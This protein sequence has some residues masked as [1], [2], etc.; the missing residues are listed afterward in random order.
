MPAQP[1]LY[2]CFRLCAPYTTITPPQFET[3]VSAYASI[4]CSLQYGLERA[5]YELM[6][7]KTAGMDW[8]DFR[9]YLAASL[10]ELHSVECRTYFREYRL[11]HQ[12]EASPHKARYA[13]EDYREVKLSCFRKLKTMQMH[14]AQLPLT[15]G[16]WVA[17]HG[18][19]AEKC[20]CWL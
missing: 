6:P 19:Q 18:A 16:C 14:K 2:A 5:C 20:T 8:S 7:H 12:Y 3:M 4:T 1:S 9:G 17:P 13:Y 11:Q 10:S 15:A